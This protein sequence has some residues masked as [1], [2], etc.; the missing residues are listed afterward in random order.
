MKQPDLQAGWSSAWQ[1]LIYPDL[2]SE[3]LQ[4]LEHG[5]EDAFTLSP[6]LPEDKFDTF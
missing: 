2:F 1:R 6:F 3:L 4:L 5:C